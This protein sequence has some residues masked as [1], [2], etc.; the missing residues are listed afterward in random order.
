MEM[1]RKSARCLVESFWYRYDASSLPLLRYG[2]TGNGEIEQVSDEVTEDWSSQPE[3][4]GRK[5]IKS[6]GC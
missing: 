5:A 4:P 1:G 3:K 6:G 2:R